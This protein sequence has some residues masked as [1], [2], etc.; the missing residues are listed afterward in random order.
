MP[1]P[2][3]KPHRGRGKRPN[4][5]LVADDDA[6]VPALPRGLN[7]SDRRR[8]W[9]RAV[10]KSPVATKWDPDLDFEA[11]LR[12]GHLYEITDPSAAVLAQI[13]RLENDLLLN[14]AARQKAYVTLPKAATERTAQR[15]PSAQQRLAAVDAA[16]PRARLAAMRRRNPAVDGLP[17][18]SAE[19]FDD[20]DP[21][22]HIDPRYRLNEG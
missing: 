22:R 7:W 10:W 9:W 3:P 1:S 14:P 15:R 17:T 21:P 18:L 16:D 12:L 5:E 4:E 6:P 19:D 13:A 20:D 11:V 2:Y 8:K